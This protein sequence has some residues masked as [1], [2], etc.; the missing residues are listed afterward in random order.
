MATVEQS[1]M[2]TN[3]LMT[4]EGGWPLFGVGA[5]ICAS[6]MEGKATIVS[7]FFVVILLDTQATSASLFPFETF[8][9]PLPPGPAFDYLDAPA[10]RV[11]GVDIP[12]PYARNLEE[13][14]GP[15][16][17]DII[18]AARRMLTGREESRATA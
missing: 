17:K 7:S 6:I 1:V 13:I 2:K 16:V 12:M 11:T 18:M 15:Q 4:V 8:H 10:T 5:E 3:H 14:S 9:R